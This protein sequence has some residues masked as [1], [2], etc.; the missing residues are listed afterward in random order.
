MKQCMSN[1]PSIDTSN[2]TMFASSSSPRPSSHSSSSPYLSP[3]HLHTVATRKCNGLLPSILRII[4]YHL[5]RGVSATSLF[6]WDAGLVRDGCFF[7]GFLAASADGD[8]IEPGSDGRDEVVFSTEEGVALCLTAL[9]TM[10]WAF[11]KSEEREETVRMVWDT[12]KVGQNSRYRVHHQDMGRSAPAGFSEHPIAAAYNRGHPS[13]HP[14]MSMPTG[15]LEDRPLLPPLNLLRAAR[16]TESAPNTAASIDGHGANGWPTY[17][18]PGTGTSIATSAGTGV[19]SRGSPI[20]A[21]MA[22]PMSYKGDMHDPFY[23]TSGG[24]LDQFSFNAPMTGPG[25]SASAVGY[26]PR[27]AHPTA[28]YLDPGFS[29]AAIAHPTSDINGCPQFGDDCNGYYH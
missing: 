28:V 20:F 19:N 26:H 10:K 25:V 4:Q 7:A 9:S 11:S 2:P 14:F 5:K 16:R 3:H 23:H 6:E 24:D 27:V 13:S 1:S 8:T 12:R 21:N 18:P 22:G 29:G 17:T 15:S